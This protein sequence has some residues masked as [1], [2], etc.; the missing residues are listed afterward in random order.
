MGSDHFYADEAPVRRVRV[1]AFSIDVAPVTNRQFAQFVQE[2]GYITLAETPPDT[3]DYP[4][5]PAA[6]A[7]AGSLVFAPQ[8]GPA[9]LAV[10]N[11]WQFCFGADWRHPQ[12]PQSALEGLD[13]HPVVHISHQ[14]ALAY[15]DW[16]GK[17]LPT[18]A[19]WEYAARGGRDGAEYAWGEELAPQG[20]MLA[21]YWQGQFPHQN[22]A[23][24]GWEGTSPVGAFPANGFGLSDMIGNVWEWTQDW[25]RADRRFKKRK[26]SCCI[27]D[28]PRGAARGNSIDK[29]IPGVRIP[30]KVMKGGSY[31]CAENYC[32]RY[33]PAARYAQSV[34]TSTGHLG[35]RC[36]IRD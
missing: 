2:T 20:A 12:G 36:V 35:F 5:M 6:M 3:A 26:G 7:R 19:E 11:W 23:L 8:L 10:P 4:G 30:R 33:R 15:A 18:E 32:Q 17:S 9:N 27:P 16:A 1:S 13:D 28:N 34:D 21:N 31:L 22:L 14:D 29:S 24:D 25:Y